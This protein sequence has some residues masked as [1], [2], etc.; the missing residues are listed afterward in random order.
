MNEQEAFRWEA[1]HQWAIQKR[2]SGGHVGTPR[3]CSAC[4]LVTALN[5]LTGCTWETGDRYMY[6][7]CCI[8]K[9]EM[10]DWME[11]TIIAV[12]RQVGTLSAGKYVFILEEINRFPKQ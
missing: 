6:N 8:K 12:D 11:S 7:T 3:S 9:V 1:H 5:E 4:P 2:E 10:P